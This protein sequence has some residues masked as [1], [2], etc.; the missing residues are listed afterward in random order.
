MASLNTIAL[1]RIYGMLPELG[2]HQ[3]AV[4]KFSYT[5]L[6]VGAIHELPLHLEGMRNIS[7][8]RNKR[9]LD[10]QCFSSVTKISS[11]LTQ[12]FLYKPIYIW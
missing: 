10:L 3:Q 5:T 11:E 6:N 12:I 4:R 7:P 2:F 9:D 1:P 8:D